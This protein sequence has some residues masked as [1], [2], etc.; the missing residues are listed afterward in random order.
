MAFF[1]TD[2]KRSAEWKQLGG[3]GVETQ[4]RQGFYS[5]YTTAVRSIKSKKPSHFEKAILILKG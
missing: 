2:A 4:N 5:L 3:A 1:L